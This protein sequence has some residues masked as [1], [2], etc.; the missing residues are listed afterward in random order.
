LTPR[1]DVLLNKNINLAKNKLVKTVYYYVFGKDI[2]V[3]ERFST[4]GKL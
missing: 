4:S 1:G 2:F 3:D